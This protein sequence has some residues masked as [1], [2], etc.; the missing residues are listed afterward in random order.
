MGRRH[1]FN[2]VLVRM[3]A[4]VRNCRQPIA[5]GV[6]RDWASVR[7][8]GDG[9]LA[10]AAARS[11]AQEVV[12]YEDVKR[13]DFATRLLKDATGLMEVYIASFNLGRPSFGSR[14]ANA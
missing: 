8:P 7:E 6:R 4:T 2:Q 13:I 5:L 3:A 1:G 10:L 9:E 14:S 11:R 12:L